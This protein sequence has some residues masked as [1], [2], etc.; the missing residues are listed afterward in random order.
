MVSNAND[1]MKWETGAREYTHLM[2]EDLGFAALR[3]RDQVLVQ[4]LK[5]VLANVCKLCLDLCAVF[6][7][8]LHLAVIALR[9]LLLL[10]RRDDSPGR[11]PRTNDILICDGK[12][13]ALFYGE[14]LVRGGNGL[15]VLDHF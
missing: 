15:H 10:N 14:L 7:D 12:E 13:I 11:T 4:N 9:L 5:N 8:Q 1:V 3:G 2:V 6:L